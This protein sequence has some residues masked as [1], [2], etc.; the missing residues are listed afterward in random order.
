MPR[1]CAAD[2]V[3][4]QSSP[5]ELGHTGRARA[6][7]SLTRG[8]L[9]WGVVPL[10]GLMLL[11]GV[12]LIERSREDDLDDVAAPPAYAAAD[13]TLL[14]ERLQQV[15]RIEL[16][17]GDVLHSVAHDG[18]LALSS[19]REATEFSDCC[20]YN[21][22][23]VYVA[24]SDGADARRLLDGENDSSPDWS[25]D[26][27]A[28]AFR[29]TKLFGASTPGIYIFDMQAETAR[30]LVEQPAETLFHRVEWSPDGRLIAVSTYDYTDEA[31]SILLVDA[32][33]GVLAARIGSVYLPGFAWSPDGSRLAYSRK[34]VSPE[35]PAETNFGDVAVVDVATAQVGAVPRTATKSSQPMI[36]SASGLLMHINRGGGRYVAARSVDPLLP[37][38][39]IMHCDQQRPC[40]FPKVVLG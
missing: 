33:T 9:K 8:L 25:P 29:R 37:F 12:V 2:W 14:D 1:R 35:N 15:G 22:V 10:A 39:V 36:W 7:G 40:P 24:E 31:T 38:R 32:A 13:G 27:D 34:T 30:L 6:E 11:A 26:G 23:V 3:D 16:L 4:S 5:S 18:R 20:G 17:E 19:A 21:K 28:L